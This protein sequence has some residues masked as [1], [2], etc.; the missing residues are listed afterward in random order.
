MER[1]K[2]NSSPTKAASSD[3]EADFDSRQIKNNFIDECLRL[4][5]EMQ[6]FTKEDLINE[7]ITM[8]L[9]VNRLLAIK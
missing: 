3:S 4:S 7:S 1:Y 5:I 2:S 8:L 6:S 9:S